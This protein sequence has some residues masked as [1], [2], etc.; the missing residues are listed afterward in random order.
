MEHLREELLA[1]AG[2]AE[3]QNGHVVGG[4][5]PDELVDPPHGRPDA[6]GRRRGCDRRSQQSFIE[7]FTARLEHEGNVPDLE[8]EPDGQ[9]RLRPRDEPC[10]PE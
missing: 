7:P 9:L 6:G 10:P 3:Q 1:D 2:L 8:N 4:D 5:T